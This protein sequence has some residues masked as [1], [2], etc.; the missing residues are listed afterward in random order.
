MG[1]AKA[2]PA[3]TAAG[4]AGGAGKPAIAAVFGPKPVAGTAKTA[5]PGGA[6]GIAAGACILYIYI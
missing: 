3:G 4:A 5:A 1:G 6:T 2:G